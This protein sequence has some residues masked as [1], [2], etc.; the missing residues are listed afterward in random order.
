MD[1]RGGPIASMLELVWLGATGSLRS[2]EIASLV[3]GASV[4]Q[5]QW[6]HARGRAVRGLAGGSRLGLVWVASWG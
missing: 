2:W 5:E 6:H 3:L 1:D 4:T